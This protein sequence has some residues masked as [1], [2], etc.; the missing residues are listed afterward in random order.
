[1]VLHIALLTMVATGPPPM[2]AILLAAWHPQD[3]LPFTAACVSAARMTFHA[4]S[5]GSSQGWSL[6]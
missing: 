6:G 1:V 3:F 4:S 5:H 2:L